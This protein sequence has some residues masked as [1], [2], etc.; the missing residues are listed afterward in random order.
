MLVKAAN[1]LQHCWAETWIAP[2]IMSI[3]WLLMPWLPSSQSQLQPF[4]GQCRIKRCGQIS[5]KCAI[6]VLRSV[7]YINIPPCLLK[8]CTP[9]VKGNDSWRAL[10]YI[11]HTSAG[12]KIFDRSDVVGA[13]PAGTAPTTTSFSTLHLASL[14]WAKT[15]ARWDEN[16]LNFVI[17]CILY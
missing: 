14:D 5:M 16:H 13:L 6:S 2:W 4:Y 7:K 17:W 8:K 1:R 3:P 11:R 9:R 15:T 12:N 10:S